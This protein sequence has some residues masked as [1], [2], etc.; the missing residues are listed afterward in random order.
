MTIAALR[1]DDDARPR[2]L[3][4]PGRIEV[5]D[6]ARDLAQVL[7]R[8]VVLDQPE[9]GRIGDRLRPRHASV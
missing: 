5:A 3:G 2:L 8:L 4:R 6:P 7:V 1:L 9:R